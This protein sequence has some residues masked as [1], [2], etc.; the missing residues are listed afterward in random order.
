M[1]Y[2]EAFGEVEERLSYEP[3]ALGCGPCGKT[4]M[5]TFLEVRLSTRNNRTSFNDIYSCTE[6]QTQRIWG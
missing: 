2:T 3:A 4:T 5:H 1:I 6:C